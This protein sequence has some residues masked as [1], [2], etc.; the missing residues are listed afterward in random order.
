M[1]S[2]ALSKVTL[3]PDQISTVAQ[4]AN[5]AGSSSGRVPAPVA[6]PNVFVPPNVANV[7]TLQTPTWP[8]VAARTLAMTSSPW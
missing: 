1:S 8:N 3:L 6:N 2:S 7:G 5:S 4:S